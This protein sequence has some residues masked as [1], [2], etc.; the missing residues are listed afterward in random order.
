MKTVTLRGKYLIKAPKDKVY[1][2]ISDFERSVKLFPDV[3]K[4]MTVLERNG[5]N[6][7]IEAQ[8][9][10]SKFSK[11]FTVHMDTQLN[12]PHGFHSI[13]TSSVG[14]EDETVRL[15]DAEDGTIFD[16]ENTMQITNKFYRPIANLFVGKFALKFWEKKYIA[17]LKRLLESKSTKLPTE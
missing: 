13:N 8:T 11:T 1:E 14:V 6:L 9:K 2:L 12:P 15:V 4:S 10:P 7:K 5:I 17:P 16:Y 3:A